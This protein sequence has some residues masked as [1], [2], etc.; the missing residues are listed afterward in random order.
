MNENTDIQESALRLRALVRVFVS[1]GVWGIIVLQVLVQVAGRGAPATEEDAGAAMLR[2]LFGS[3][4]IVA[5]L[6]M[7]AGVLAALVRTRGSVSIVD[8]LNSAR[9]VFFSFVWLVVRAALVLAGIGMIAG[10][11]VIGSLG[12]G[13]PQAIASRL[14]PFFLA[15][16]MLL[17][18]LFVYWLPHVFVHNDF[19]LFATLKQALTLFWQRRTQSWYLA[20]LILL[21]AVGAGMLPSATPFAIRLILGGAIM[22]LAWAANTYCIE[23]LVTQRQVSPSPQTK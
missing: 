22:L 7:Q 2:M 1:P 15:T 3:I 16:A 21:P 9:T 5:M 11:V 19:R 8:V 6:Y 20:I 23:W 18:F 17:P 10:V 12:T 13:D 14:A 4:A